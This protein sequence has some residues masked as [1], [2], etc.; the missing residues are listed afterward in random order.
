MPFLLKAFI[1]FFAG[2]IAGILN[3][4]A[5]GGTLIT[6]PALMFTGAPSIIANATNTVALQV[7]TIATLWAY[8][9]EF[10]TQKK[11]AWRYGPLSALG[12]LLGAVLLLHTR[13]GYFRAGVPYLILFATILFTLQ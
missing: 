10:A 2:A 8:R 3:A 13:E 1:L 6:F 9:R 12:G 11:A 7:G 4:L 5:G